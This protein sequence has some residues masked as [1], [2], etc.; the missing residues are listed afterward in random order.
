MCSL[1]IWH[2]FL[3]LEATSTLCQVFFFFEN[4]G[5]LEITYGVLISVHQM[6]MRHTCPMQRLTEKRRKIVPLLQCPSTNVGSFF[7]IFELGF[8]NFAILTP[9]KQRYFYCKSSQKWA[10]RL[11]TLNYF[12]VNWPLCH[13]SKNSLYHKSSVIASWLNIV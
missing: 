10:A 6:N 7:V 11:C 4:F 8:W 3:E 13:Y 9:V 1:F 5:Q 12:V 2:V